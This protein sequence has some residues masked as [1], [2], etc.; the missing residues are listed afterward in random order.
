MTGTGV[1]AMVLGLAVVTAAIK[2]FGPLLLGGRV[3]PPSVTAVVA[4]LPPALLAALVVTTVATEGRG[5]AVDARVVGVAAAG[6][7]LWLR[8]PL[9]V[10]VLVASGVTAA[11]RA[12]T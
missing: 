1:W 2:A 9:L 7:L 11:V 3:L 10:A 12:L 4:L 8:C 5:F 6:V